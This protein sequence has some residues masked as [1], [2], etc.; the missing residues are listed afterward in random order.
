[1]PSNLIIEFDHIALIASRM[2]AG[3]VCEVL[4]LTVA[5]LLESLPEGSVEALMEYLSDV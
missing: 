1:M 4:D 3:E 2:T 5:E